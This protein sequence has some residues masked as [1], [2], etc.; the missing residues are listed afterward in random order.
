MQTAR[1]L[2]SIWTM[3]IARNEPGGCCIGWREQ[4]MVWT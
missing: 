3:P 4:E 2:K 1:C